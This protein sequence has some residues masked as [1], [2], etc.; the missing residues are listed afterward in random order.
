MTT[1]DELLNVISDTRGESVY[2]AVQQAL[3][4]LADARGEE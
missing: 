4:A 1:L 3:R 2:E